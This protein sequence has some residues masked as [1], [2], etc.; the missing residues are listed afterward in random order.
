MSEKKYDV[1]I[2]GAGPGGYRAAERAGASG[3]KTLVIERDKSLGGVCLNRG[4]IP[5]KALLN[6]A[7]AFHS[8]RNSQQLGVVC[9]GVEYDLTKAME[10]KAKTVSALTKGVA[11]QMRRHNVDVITGSAKIVGRNI[12]SAGN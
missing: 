1:V 6:S 7:K 5:T 11:Y 3:K 10:W 8:A 9:S 12:V 2:I 4:C